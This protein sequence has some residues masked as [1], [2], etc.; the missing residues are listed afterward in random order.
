M[1]NLAVIAYAADDLR[2]EDAG[3]VSS[4][5]DEAVVRIAYGGVC[6]SDLHYWKHGAAGAS[7]LR[8]PMIL[9]HEVSGVVE[10]AAADGSGPD[11]GTRV[12][13]H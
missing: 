12:V 10:I 11:A 8:E 9:G 6:G 2:V 3:P 13:V 1:Q 7:V 5:A 4:A